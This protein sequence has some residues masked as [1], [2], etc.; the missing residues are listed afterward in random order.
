MCGPSHTDSSGY[1]L[2]R[3]AL[4]PK[5]HVRPCAD[6][7]FGALAGRLVLAQ[8][9]IAMGFSLDEVLG[10][11]ERIAGSRRIARCRRRHSTPAS[12]LH[13]GGLVTPGC[14]ARQL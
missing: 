12:L 5:T 8:G 7:R 3:R 6:L 10:T 11:G 1:F 13:A 2:A 9:P 4:I 14:H